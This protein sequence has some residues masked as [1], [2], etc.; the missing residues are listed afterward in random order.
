MSFL[1]DASRYYGFARYLRFFGD[2][3][4]VDKGCLSR[5]EKKAPT[6]LLTLRIEALHRFEPTALDVDSYLN[7]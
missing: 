3:A 2:G 7:F 6:M 1:R 4:F 5:V